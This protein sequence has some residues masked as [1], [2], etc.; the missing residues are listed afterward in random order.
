[1]KIDLREVVLVGK[2]IRLV[3]ISFDFAE[4]IFQEFTPE[5]TTFM[6]PKSPNDISDIE[7]WISSATEKVRKGQDLQTVII[8]NDN[9]E[10]LG[11]AGLHSLDTKTPELGIW[12]K[13][14]AHGQGFG[15]EAIATLKEWAEQNLDYKYLKYPVDRKNIPSR[16]IPE[17][18]GGIIEDEYKKP[19]QAGQILDEVE[20]RI[21]KK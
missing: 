12:I 9:N 21:Y 1:M 11:C 2:R 14:S 20:Y 5:I 10:F 17:S 4:Q 3:P 7:K 13:K 15:Q 8:K 16:K 6:Y 19:N 18:L